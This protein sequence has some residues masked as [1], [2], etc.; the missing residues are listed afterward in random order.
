MQIVGGRG[1]AGLALYFDYMSGQR[2]GAIVASGVAE[3]TPRRGAV[4]GVRAPRDEHLPAPLVDELAD[5][6]S[7]RLA[8]RLA[9]LLVGRI[10]DLTNRDDEG[11]NPVLWLPD[12]ARYATSEQLATRY[13]LSVQWVEARAPNLGATPISDSRNSK[14]R[15][16][17]A[18]ADAYMDARRRRPPARIRGTGGRKPKP[19]KRTHTRTGRPLLEVE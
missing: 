11:R 12:G 19:S 17:L 9:E 13:Q 18:T 5:K 4:G 10:A 8:D 1:S 6:L 15:Y 16:H 2:N 3:L 14:L 7:K